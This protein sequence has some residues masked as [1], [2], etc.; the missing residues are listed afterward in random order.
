[1][2]ST[3]STAI[4]TFSTAIRPSA[5]LSVQIIGAF[6]TPDPSLDRS[7]PVSDDQIEVSDPLDPDVGASD[8]SLQS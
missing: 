4:S 8:P 1:M 5:E 2:I 3:L 7:D 6:K